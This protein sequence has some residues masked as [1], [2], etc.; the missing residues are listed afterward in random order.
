[1]M[2]W[3][4]LQNNLSMRFALWGM[5]LT[6]FPMI[7]LIAVWES[8]QRLFTLTLGIVLFS[9]SLVLVSMG[10]HIGLIP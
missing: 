5:Y 3:Y 7:I 9:V 1:M 4:G 2:V 8:R 10:I 6:F